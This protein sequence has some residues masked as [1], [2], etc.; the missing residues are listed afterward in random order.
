MN[1]T[2]TVDNSCENQIQKL[3]R[4]DSWQENYTS[5]FS[6]N[7]EFLSGNKIAGIARKAIIFSMLTSSIT[8][9]NDLWP[10]EK[11]WNNSV[12]EISE[13]SF[14]QQ[15]KVMGRSVSLTEALQITKGILETAEQKR[16]RFAEEEAALGIQWEN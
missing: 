10:I 15:K 2:C 6:N 9:I 1:N 5:S 13:T 16:L 12:V 3:S 11:G 14:T 4:T 8:A 7:F